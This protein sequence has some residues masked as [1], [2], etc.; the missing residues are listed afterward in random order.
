MSIRE[1]GLYSRIAWRSIGRN[2][3]RT[4][5]TLASVVFGTMAL[6][7]FNGVVDGIFEQ[8]REYVI[9]S[10]LGHLQITVPGYREF[11]TLD[12]DKYSLNNFVELKKELVRIPGV[13]DVT[14]RFE[15]FGFLSNG[16]A[17]VASAVTGVEADIDARTN[18]AI[19]YL[20]GAP[21]K[22]GQAAASVGVGLATKLHLKVGDNVT[23]LTN[24]GKNA[25]NAVDL[26]ISGIFESGVEAFDALAL[27][28]P[29]E[30]TRTLLNVRDDAAHTV[31]VVLDQTSRTE[32]AAAAIRQLGASR[33]WP[34]DVQTWDALSPV[35][36]KV[37]RLFTAV[38]VFLRVVVTL[39]VVFSIMNTITMSVYERFREIGSIRAIG[40]PRRAVAWLFVLEGA[41]IGLLGGVAGALLANIPRLVLNGLHLTLPPPPILTIGVPLLILFTPQVIVQAIVVA[42]AL[43]VLASIFPA[44]RA[45]RVS[46]VTALRDA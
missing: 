27:T 9:H 29:M 42:T 26:D 36:H 34:L 23:L 41:F 18:T 35:Y 14:K 10:R 37:I 20:S 3:R 4:A 5:L 46:I 40:T 6:V 7:L 17:T 38:L 16:E 2:R 33:N 43:S 31:V 45:G 19:K 8:L 22:P 1:F 13:V 30:S 15:F 28:L 11:G 32:Q 39:V 44:R 12:P 25:V 21:P 24:Y